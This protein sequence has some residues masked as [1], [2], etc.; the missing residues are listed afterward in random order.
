[1]KSATRN[2]IFDVIIRGYTR[3]DTRA[4]RVFDEIDG[5]DGPDESDGKFLLNN[6]VLIFLFVWP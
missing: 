4:E 6:C 3:T 2:F 1:M 5:S